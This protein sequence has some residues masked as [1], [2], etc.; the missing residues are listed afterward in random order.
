MSEKIYSA[1]VAGG[2][3]IVGREIVARL[4]ASPDYDRVILLTRREVATASGIEP[5]VVD[6]DALC[7]SGALPA[8]DHVYLAIGTTQKTAGSKP[9]FRRVDYDYNVAVARAARDAGAQ[10]AALVSSVG[11][12]AAS[13]NFYIR[14]K[15]ETEDAVGAMGFERLSIA[16]PGLL[17]GPRD[18][19]RR[20]GESLAK[21]VSPVLD[22]FM[23]G[24][25]RKYR[26]IFPSVVA[27][28]LVN[29]TLDG[30]P[31]VEVMEHDQL[32]DWARR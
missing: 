25:A 27:D 5:L 12:N 29:A 3:G 1:L 16:R 28:A 7:E 26:S 11:A 19:G 32:N 10:R 20:I 21:V 2:T 15:G 6:F 31:G 30:E 22:G 13:G 14:I 23:L 4:A 9:A 17:R 18:N 8:V 24:A